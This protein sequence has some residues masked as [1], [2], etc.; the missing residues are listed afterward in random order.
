MTHRLVIYSEAHEDIFRNADWWAA[1][2]SLDQAIRWQK[3]IYSQLEELKE[4]PERRPLAAENPHFP[5]DIR[6][7]FVGLGSRPRYRAIFTIRDDAVHI[8]T[9]LDAAQEELELG[10]IKVREE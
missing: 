4:M 5:F 2:H 6:E 7:A 3:A 1:N 8:L 10:E 9:V